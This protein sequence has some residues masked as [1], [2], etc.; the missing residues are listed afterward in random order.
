[1]AADSSLAVLHGFCHKSLLE[2]S[3]KRLPDS[4]A[5]SQHPVFKF[6]HANVHH[7]NRNGSVVVSSSQRTANRILTKLS[8]STMFVPT[9]FHILSVLYV[10]R[11]MCF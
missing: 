9:H 10:I 11:T 1:M 5:L 7:R 6:V 3:V 2:P 4:P 8:L